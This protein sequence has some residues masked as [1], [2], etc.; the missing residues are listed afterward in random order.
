MEEELEVILR[1]VDEASD[2]FES[3]TEAAENMGESVQ[4]GAE[5]G[6]QGL[7]EM[8][9]SGEAAADPL[10]QISSI[11]GGLAGA[12]I[13]SQLAD[14]LW[15]FADKA[16]SFEDSMMRARLEAE[17]AG[18]SVNEMTDTVSE[19]SRVTG[20]AGGEI[21]ESFIKATARGITDMD[22]FK[23]MMV[24]AGAQATLLGTDIQSMGDKFSSMA[25]RSTLM[26]RQLASTGIT[27]EEL[28]SAM[29]MTGA[30]ADEVKAKWQELDTNQR[31]AA[32]GMAASMNE[33]QTANEEYKKSWAGLQE[34]LDIARGRLERL[35]GEV[36]LP[37]LVP[38]LEVAGRVLNWL[39]DTI[40][41]VM[42][43][44]LGGLISVVGAA[45]AAFALAVPAYMAVSGAITLLTATA[46]PA[47][48][49]LWAMVAP[50]LPFIAVGA[51]VV[52]IIYEIGKAF[53]WWTDVSSM[54]DA[55][56]AGVQRLWSAFINHPDVQSFL[57]AL[58][59][60]WNWLVPAV[61]GVVNAVLRFFGVSSSSNFDFVRALID[62]VGVAW[63]AMTTPIRLVITVVKLLWN[64][65]TQWYNKT[66]TN[67]QNVQKLFASLPGIIRGLVSGLANIITAPFHNAYK[68]VSSAVTKIKSAAQSITHININS[69][70]DK[71]ISPFKNAYS[72]IVSWAK[73]TYSDAQS[74]YNSIKPKSSS[75]GAYGFDL[76]GMLE[77]INKQ[78]SSNV[79]TTGN[80]S[81]TLDHNINFSFDFTNLPEGTSEE[82]LVA[83]LRS[84]I[85]D[86]S[87]INSLVN[88]PD[89][90]SLD[91]K[92]KDR[93]LLKSGRARGV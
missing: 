5:A 39:G 32:L 45:A 46:I 82:T 38:A 33:G 80:E 13:F 3:V 23:K 57:S 77:E 69:V 81:L 31:A 9:E 83:M 62:A 88:S 41:M 14:T 8:E 92:V 2:T 91:G 87:V 86:R 20:R 64:T 85:T 50:L 26:E 56:W 6:S 55:I 15:D 7:D 73:K 75:G 18:I 59:S 63:K 16:G 36:L 71:L 30:T 35:A 44:P 19:L 28:A 37:V 72:S 53:G 43:G 47:A 27:M 1:A 49:A 54:L 17:G 67:V 93:L 65:I 79:Y 10:E 12:E 22:S 25:M 58:A 11:M 84:A 48:T 90:Q 29:G 52:L 78:K 68:G 42:K 66:K 60:A 76:E 40:S 61:T 89:F 24:G 21:R 34:Q 51:A 74:W 70:K 4:G